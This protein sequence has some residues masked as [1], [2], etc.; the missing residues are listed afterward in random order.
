MPE[1]L[2]EQWASMRDVHAL[3]AL[4]Y[5]AM[6]DAHRELFHCDKFEC[7]IFDQNMANFEMAVRNVRKFALLI[8]R[9]DNVRKGN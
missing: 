6:A 5:L 8:E 2:R 9:A 1:S 7:G 3:H 4:G